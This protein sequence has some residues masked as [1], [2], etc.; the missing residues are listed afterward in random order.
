MT[1]Y[2][3]ILKKIKDVTGIQT[4]SLS[5]MPGRLIV[6]DTSIPKCL[7]DVSD[8]YN[9]PYC[10]VG[11]LSDVGLTCNDLE[12]LG[13]LQPLFKAPI[14]VDSSILVNQTL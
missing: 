4:I 3:K 11:S 6:D 9:A 5:T 8:Y 1:D 14:I 12:D 10:N 2:D 7:C 13:V